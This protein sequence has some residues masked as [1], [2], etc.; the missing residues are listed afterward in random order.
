MR[1]TLKSLFVAICIL[2]IFLQ[3]ASAQNL[4]VIY[5]EATNTDELI[6]KEGQR[7]TVYGVTARS[8]KSESGMNFVNFKDATFT[9]VTFKSD[10]SAFKEG[11]PADIF[12]EKRIAVRGVISIYKDK[13]QIKLTDPGWVEVLTEEEVFPP[14]MDS[15]EPAA[16]KKVSPEPK[17][18]GKETPSQPEPKKKPPVDPKKYFK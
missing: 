3:T 16:K 8:G 4:A 17:A 7:V 2:G 6:A 13:P 18:K 10:L 11:E 1:T 5:I 14:K 12:D 9:L 15:P